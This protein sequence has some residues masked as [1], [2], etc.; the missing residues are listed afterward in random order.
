[1]ATLNTKL[2]FVLAGLFLASCSEEFGNGPRGPEGP[3]GPDGVKGESGFLFEYSNISF[4]APDFEVYL[5]Y[6]Q[7][8]EG[9][10]SDMHLV[11]FLWDVQEDENGDPLDIWRLLPQTI[12]TDVGLL[13]YNYDA[14]RID[15]RLFMDAEFD[16]EAL[17][18]LDTD[19]WVVRVVVIPATNWNAR[20]AVDFKDYQAV[21]KAYGLPELE[22]SDDVTR[23]LKKISRYNGF[24]QA[25]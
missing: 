9:L 7:D 5:D 21:E 6:P 17:G 8:F 13:Q 16:L 23:R 19:N 15:T 14:S 2:L 24:T 18:A 12:L 25:G 22:R 10:E 1:M 3:V 11:Y 20:I 4:T